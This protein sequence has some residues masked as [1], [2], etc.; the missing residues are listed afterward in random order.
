MKPNETAS[1]NDF[2]ILK[3]HLNSLYDVNNIFKSFEINDKYNEVLDLSNVFTN[4]IYYDYYKIK[5]EDMTIFKSK[6]I[7][8]KLNLIKKIKEKQE[9]LQEL[10]RELKIVNKE[11]FE[12]QHEK[13]SLQTTI[14]NLKVR[15]NKSFCRLKIIHMNMSSKHSLL[16]SA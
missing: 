1:D 8:H 14:N 3:T 12:V 4:N 7:D 10:V 6:L 5:C 13:E 11:K 9:I 15:S 16:M 2:D